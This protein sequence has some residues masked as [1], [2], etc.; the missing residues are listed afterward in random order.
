MF[1][2]KKDLLLYYKLMKKSDPYTITRK[3]IN[4]ISYVPK[5]KLKQFI[6]I[7][8]FQA[9]DWS[10]AGTYLQKQPLLCNV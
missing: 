9:R 6:A 2:S 10:Y 5:K 3:E 1:R 7:V 8:I 4:M